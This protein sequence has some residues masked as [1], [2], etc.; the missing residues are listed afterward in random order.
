ML[1]SLSKQHYSIGC[2][3]NMLE[4]NLNERFSLLRIPHQL[5]D[6]FVISL[7]ELLQLDMDE[8]SI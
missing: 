6:I 1:L 5:T 4:A 7:E 8:T 2:Y 3:A